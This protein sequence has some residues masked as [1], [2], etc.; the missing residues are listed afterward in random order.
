MTKHYDSYDEFA[1]KT[2]KFVRHV[3]HMYSKVFVNP[4]DE[5]DAVYEAQKLLIDALDELETSRKAMQDAADEME[6]YRKALEKY[7][8]GIRVENRD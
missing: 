5:R 3:N 4:E 1:T 7:G 2:N 6:K 8:Q